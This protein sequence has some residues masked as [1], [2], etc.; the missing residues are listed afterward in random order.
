MLLGHVVMAQYAMTG[1]TEV[2]EKV[3]L[4][5]IRELD[6]LFSFF[7]GSVTWSPIQLPS[8]VVGGGVPV[9]PLCG[10]VCFLEGRGEVVGVEM[11]VPVV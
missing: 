3:S 5:D 6:C 9:A 7:L 10:G 2:L 11:K 8:G 4:G 1:V